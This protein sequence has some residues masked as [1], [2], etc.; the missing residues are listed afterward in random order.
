MQDL[1]YKHIKITW[2]NPQINENRTLVHFGYDLTI[3][4]IL[5]LFG[6]ITNER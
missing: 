5:S 4:Y 3:V 2:H 6:T 1:S